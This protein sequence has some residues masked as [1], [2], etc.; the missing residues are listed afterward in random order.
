MYVSIYKYK[1][2]VYVYAMHT[3]LYIA[4]PLGSIYSQ[5][6]LDFETLSIISVSTD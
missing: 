6:S 5:T 2:A 1:Y 4:D 3:R